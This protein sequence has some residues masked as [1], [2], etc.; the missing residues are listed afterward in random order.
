LAGILHQHDD[1]CAAAILFISP[2]LEFHDLVVVHDVPKA[3]RPAA[4]F[5]VF[6]VGLAADRDVEHYR[7][8]FA[9]VRASEEV[10]HKLL[11]Y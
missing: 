6:D 2:G 8:L 5:A 1:C 9:T 10:F 7:N 11:V 3:Y 4:H